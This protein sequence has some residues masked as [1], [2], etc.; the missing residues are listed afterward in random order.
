MFDIRFKNKG[1]VRYYECVNLANLG[2]K[3]GVHD[4]I[5]SYIISSG[6]PS[7]TSA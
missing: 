6:K 3:S 1:N 5:M 2:L 4:K 7:D